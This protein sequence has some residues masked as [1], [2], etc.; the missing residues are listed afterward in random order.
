MIPEVPSKPD[1]TQTAQ[2]F[3]IDWLNT[4]RLE[5]LTSYMETA[6]HFAWISSGFH[7]MPLQL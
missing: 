1:Q 6:Q 2:T 4:A 3:D 5:D 7:V